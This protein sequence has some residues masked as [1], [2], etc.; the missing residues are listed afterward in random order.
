MMP[1]TQMQ[2]NP[3]VR[4]PSL[5]D[6]AVGVPRRPT[7]SAPALRH[8][9]PAETQAIAD[10]FIAARTSADPLVLQAY[11]QLETQT[12]EQ[13]AALTDP[14]GPYRIT[15]VGTSEATPYSDARELIAS[16]LTSRTLE[17][18]TSAADRAHPLLGGEVGGAY[19]RFRA[20]HDLIGHVATGYGF[21][22]DGEYSAWLTQRSLYA[23]LARW[24]AATEL[25]GEISTLWT[26]QQF[27][28]HKAVLLDP[29]L[30]SRDDHEEP[31]DDRARNV[32]ER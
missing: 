3:W 1:V 28:E 25:H 32:R 9:Q 13:F 15:V 16:V 10:C 4:F 6:P 5:V 12:D 19:F 11:Q 18:T 2:P 17:V 24:A 23:G 20:V 26:T 14:R 29:R 31:G 21:D 30:L 27:A 22:R 8:V 7:R